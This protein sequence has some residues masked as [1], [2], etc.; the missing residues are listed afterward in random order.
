M[1]F[2]RKNHPP[3]ASP[4]HFAPDELTPSRCALRYPENWPSQLDYPASRTARLPVEYGWIENGH[5]GSSNAADTRVNVRL[6][7]CAWREKLVDHFNPMLFL[8]GPS[9]LSDLAAKVFCLKYISRGN[10]SG[11]ADSLLNENAYGIFADA[12]EVA[13]D[14]L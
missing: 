5:D 14:L 11:L 1:R 12:T 10:E 3:K 4:L 2:N 9:S 7:W 6:V 8:K 13:R